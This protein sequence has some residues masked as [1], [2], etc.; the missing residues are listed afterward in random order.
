[1]NWIIAVVLLAV[2]FPCV[3]GCQSRPGTAVDFVR[4]YEATVRPV[5]IELQ[6]AWWKA[7]TT[8][9]DEDFKHKERVQNRLDELLSNTRQFQRLEAIRGK[10][11]SASP[12]PILARQ[13]EVL[14]LLYRSRQVDPDL[15]KRI[16]AK[17][18][19]IEQK[20]NVFRARVDG[21]ELTDSEVT[22][23]LK[24][25][26]DSAQRRRVWEASKAVAPLVLDDLKEVVALRNQAARRLGFRNYYDMQLR[27]GEQDPQ[28]VLRLFDELHELTREPF[29]K[30]KDELDVRLAANCGVAV[31]DLRPWHYHDKF[32]QEPPS[33]YQV[34]LDDF[35][36][37]ADIP[38][39]T[40]K[41]FAGIGLPVDAILA[42]SDL[43]E[44]PGKSPHGFCSDMDRD[45]DVR[46]LENIVPNREWMAVTLHECGHAVYA[47]P[48][49]PR[50][51]PYVLRTPAHSFTTEG[52]AMMFEAMASRADWMAAMGIPVADVRAAAETGAKMQRSHLLIFA[53]WSQ[54]MVRFEM[55]MYENP[56]QDLN[57]LW[58]DLVEK[59]QMVKRPE[60]RN[61]PDY[62]SK[63]HICVSPCYY[64]N[65]TLGQ[66]FASQLHEA[67]AR[68]AL[69]TEPANALYNNR[70]EVGEFLK[71][72]VFAPANTMRWDAFVKYATGEALSAKAFAA[73]MR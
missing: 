64:H 41:Y 8:G 52:V 20:F 12:D 30:V 21:R 44:R 43:Y 10:L 3:V 71:A 57:K 58:W 68:Q 61:A 66:L 62:A 15:L 29:R 45:G 9:K 65:Y 16:A 32:F 18:N 46:V 25:S 56:D 17:E 51:V 38:D 36:A 22:S 69:K 1:M 11:P 67:I 2:A 4:D 48:N 40:R 5:E 49:I 14:H 23:V 47:A 37:K 19:V 34:N 31:A 63:I 42:R 33:I 60:G 26:K 7:S 53:A 28:E 24:E 13:I 35:Y 59:Y 6:H 39:L 54:V 55:A 73:E 70:P 27:L 72:R 50:T